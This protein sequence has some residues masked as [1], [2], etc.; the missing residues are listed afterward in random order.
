MSRFNELA[1][2]FLHIFKG[3][4]YLTSRPKLWPWAILP[5]AINLI[6]LVV[7]V[8]AFIHYYHDLYGWLSSQLGGLDI[9]NPDA[10][11]MYILGGILWVINIILQIFIVLL[12]LI[13]LLI[14]SYCLSF[15]IAA[16][17][18]DILSEKVEILETSQEAPPFTFGKF[19]KD[20]LRVMKI[21]SI[22]AV[23]LLTIPIFLF[24]L[25]FLP[26]IGAALY[27]IATIIFGSWDIGFAFADLPMGRKV[28]SLRERIDFATKNKW[29]LIGFGAGFI[30][31]FFTLIFGAPMVVGGT[32]LYLKKIANQ[33]G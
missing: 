13:L 17:F 23:I 25:S 4:K 33:N 24:I 19:I 14:A 20:L 9:Q 16:P 12:T 32:L 8:S 29:S 18:N 2:G 26:A 7:M 15:I 22:K 3:I 27:V 5:T 31:P 6:I 10:W 1:D 30:I 28:T 21:E 11:Y